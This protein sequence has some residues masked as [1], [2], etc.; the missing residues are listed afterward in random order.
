MTKELHQLTTVTCLG[1]ILVCF[2]AMARAETEECVDVDSCMTVGGCYNHLTFSEKV[3][4]TAEINICASIED[5]E[6]ECSFDGEQ[7][8][9]VVVLYSAYNCASGTEISGP[10][11]KWVQDAVGDDCP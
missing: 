3:S 6:S 9:A 5:V 8:C 7:L 11:Q 10:V 1:A 2:V 4:A